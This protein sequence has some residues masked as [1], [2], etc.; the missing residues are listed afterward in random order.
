MLVDSFYQT[1]SS[2]SEREENNDG[3][4]EIEVYFS[5]SN[6][7]NAPVILQSPAPAKKSGS[8]G[9]NKSSR[10]A[11]KEA[12]THLVHHQFFLEKF[13]RE[14]TR[15]RHTHRIIGSFAF[16]LM[17]CAIV[18]IT[19]GRNEKSNSWFS[20]KEGESNKD[21]SPDNENS[22]G[23]SSSNNNQGIN[24]NGTETNDAPSGE[25][26]ILTGIVSHKPIYQHGE[27]IHIS[28]LF[29][30]DADPNP[31]D[32]IGLYPYS[33]NLHILLE[34]VMFLYTCNKLF[35]CDKMVRN[36]SKRLR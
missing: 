15:R 22:N 2:P 36:E 24:P 10:N 30:Y 3:D 26:F 20:S 14:R 23:S 27:E 12:S 16:L 4:E 35:A 9:A 25:T 19:L 5:D 11:T 31:D 18:F 33:E 17:V 6:G 28:F 32:W 1:R 29:G 21:K 7:E 34:P 13:N 8:N